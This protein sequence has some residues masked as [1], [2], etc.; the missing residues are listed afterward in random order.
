MNLSVTFLEHVLRRPL[1]L[2]LDLTSFLQ[3]QPLALFK[4]QVRQY[5]LFVL[6]GK[7]FHERQI[8]PAGKVF[9]LR[10][11]LHDGAGLAVT[12]VGMAV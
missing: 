4:R 3:K 7:F 2:Q 1:H 6:V 12:D 11:Q 9:F 8:V 5:P 10:A